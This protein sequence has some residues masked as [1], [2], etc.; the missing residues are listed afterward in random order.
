MWSLLQARSILTALAPTGASELLKITML[1]LTQSPTIA[2]VAGESAKTLV[3]V[4]TEQTSRL[5]KKI[6]RLLREPLLRGMKLLSEALTLKLAAPEQTQARDGLLE[7]AHQAFLS[8]WAIGGDSNEDSAF[9]LAL[10]TLALKNH[11]GLWPLAESKRAEFRSSFAIVRA[12]AAAL[13]NRVSELGE[14]RE[15][16]HRYFVGDR[17]RDKPFGYTDQKALYL[18]AMRELARIEKRASIARK[19]LEILN[20][21][22]LVLEADSA[23]LANDHLANDRPRTM[24]A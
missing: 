17:N 3:T 9:I 24:G 21:L 11:S 10:D 22:A 15:D 8:A 1:A 4:L 6:D 12:H 19:N 14:H 16:L 7:A 18:K 13:E 2:G 5:E 23:D 20:T